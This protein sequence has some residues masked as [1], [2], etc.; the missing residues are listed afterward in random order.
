MK[1]VR[2]RQDRLRHLWAATK[3]P[4]EFG[5]PNTTAQKADA[6]APDK[7]NKDWMDKII[8]TLLDNKD[9]NEWT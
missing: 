1:S 9:F 7:D 8:K 6:Q 5:A 4:R 2:D 3:F